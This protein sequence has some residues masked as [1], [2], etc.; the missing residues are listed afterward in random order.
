MRPVSAIERTILHLDLDAF[1]V[2]VERLIHPELQGKPLI[3]GGKTDSNRG[4]V[5]ACSYEARKYGVHSG[6]PIATAR[7]L[8]KDA[9]F[10][11]GSYG[12]YGK[13]SAIVTQ[14]IYEASPLFEK[15]SIDEF[16]IDLSGMGRFHSS[17]QWSEELKKKIVQETGLPIS[18][19]LSTNKTVAKIATDFC[20]PDGQKHVP[21]KEIIDFLR[22]MPVEKIP[23]IGKQT[24][25]ELNNM[26]IYFI[27]DLQEI[28]PDLLTRTFG[29]WGK[30][31]WEKAHG[32]DESPVMPYR[33][34][35]SFSRE[36]TLNTES[37]DPVFLT[38]LL[39]RMADEL[40]FELRSSRKLTTCVGVK[41]RYNDFETHTHQQKIP[42]TANEK[43]LITSSRRLFY[44]LYT[45]QGRVRL[46]GLKLSDL[47]TGDMQTELFKD[48]IPGLQLRQATD[49][50]RSKFGKGSIGWAGGLFTSK[51]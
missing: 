40:A 11:K 33:E 4:V 36:Q 47:C 35:K 34:E 39:S 27:R 51:K 10:V 12:M 46:I 1:F 9:T 23:G 49:K 19:G 45:R 26:G 5:S 14:I 38:I 21:E 48:S 37:T 7:R 30:G 44:Q 24:Q 2:S 29:K 16:Y 43:D 20:K 22:P 13:Y 42:P 17:L 32:R 8:C 6:M 31:I 15:A 3:I 18:F 50:I 41:I 25:A 28:Q